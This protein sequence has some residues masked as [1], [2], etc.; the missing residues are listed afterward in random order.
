MRI[1]RIRIQLQRSP[2]GALARDPI[3]RYAVLIAQ[4]NVEFGDAVVKRDGLVHE[5]ACL[6]QGLA[7]AA[8]PDIATHEPDAG[9]S[10]ICERVVRILLE[11][12][13]EMAMSGKVEA[14]P[15]LLEPFEPAFEVGLE[16]FGVHIGRADASRACSIGDNCALI[17]RTIADTISLRRTK[18]ILQVVFVSVRPQLVAR[19]GIE[20]LRGHA[21]A[22]ARPLH[23][24]GDERIH[25]ELARDVGERRARPLETDHRAAC[26]DALESAQLARDPC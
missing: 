25:A 8:E 22:I 2:V 6:R 14:L 23:R 18:H 16:G 9:Q 10:R 17:S 12:L 24:A 4:G 20:E 3:Q 15:R 21:D 7:G 5:L 11:C 13:L 19:R 1:R 26:R